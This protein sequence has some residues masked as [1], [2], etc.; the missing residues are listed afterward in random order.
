MTGPIAH[1]NGIDIKPDAGTQISIDLAMGRK[2]KMTEGEESDE[3]TNEPTA[4]PLHDIYRSRQQ[5]RTR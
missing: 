1:E 5:K 4:P 3:E 2:R